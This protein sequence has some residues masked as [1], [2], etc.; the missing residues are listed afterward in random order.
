M[1]YKKEDIDLALR[2]VAKFK[3]LNDI[4]PPTKVK[5]ILPDYPDPVIA[6]WAIG[7]FLSD[8]RHGY[9]SK[10][11]DTLYELG[12]S[13]YRRGLISQIN[14]VCEAID[15]LVEA[16]I[17]LNEIPLKAKMSDYLEKYSDRTIN[18][19][20]GL[21]LENARQNRECEAV[22]LK[23]KEHNFNFEKISL[24]RRAIIKNIVI[25]VAKVTD[26]NTISKKAIVSDF[27]PDYDPEFANFKIGIL[28][29]NVRAGYYEFLIPTLND[30][31][32]SF[33]N[34][35]QRTNASMICDIIDDLVDNNID[36]NNIHSRALLGEIIPE[37]PNK[38]FG[39]G[40]YLRNAALG[41]VGQEVR[42]KLEKNNFV[43]IP[44]TLTSKEKIELVTKA[45]EKVDIN[46]IKK[47][48]VLSDIL[49]DCDPRYSMWNIGEFLEQNRETHNPI[50]EKELKGLGL[51]YYEKQKL[52]ALDFSIKAIRDL[53][54]A[55]I[56]LNT[57]KQRAK[58]S[59][60]IPSYSHKDLCIGALLS[61]ARR[62]EAS[63]TLMRELADHGFDFTLKPVTIPF[64]IK[65][66]VLKRAL[67]S[68]VNINNILQ[69][70]K[71]SDFV[72]LEEGERDYCIGNWIKKAERGSQD[73]PFLKEI[74]RLGYRPRKNNILS[75]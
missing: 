65:M 70:N 61:N 23:L 12:F 55:G 62:G 4:F 8:I 9:N 1:S 52:R 20:I 60:Y 27:L 22:V 69:K 50:Y 7:V 44:R 30:L 66:E 31:G 5:D 73:N 47:T 72:Q 24:T 10:Y 11:Y 14:K 29:Q 46:K 45:S 26:L 28:I 6:N 15:E 51:K 32:F 37:H 40:Q 71:L 59:D 48:A 41:K 67:D 36:L 35:K 54:E 49:P 33:K 63:K 68:G 43:F 56:D 34:V 74:I 17:D 75:K 58:M 18:F 21:T 25:D 39:I 57:I 53:V 38:D 2:R 64:E 3:D 42:A 19:T 16:G 13:F